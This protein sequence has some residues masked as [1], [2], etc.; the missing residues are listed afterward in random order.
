MTWLHIACFLIFIYILNILSIKNIQ[1]YSYNR[2]NIFS[3]S[4]NISYKY[5][6]INRIIKIWD[7]FKIIIIKGI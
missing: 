5:I 6:N 4:E 7:T 2:N 1:K 3:I